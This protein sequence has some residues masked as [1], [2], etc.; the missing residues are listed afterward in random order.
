[1]VS[2]NA[3]W[4]FWSVTL[5]LSTAASADAMLDG[6]GVV[7]VLGLAVLGAVVVRVPFAVAFEG[8]VWVDVVLGVVSVDVLVGAV[9]LGVPV[10]AV[11]LGVLVVVEPVVVV[12]AGLVVVS[13]TNSRVP[14]SAAVLAA[15][16]VVAVP[17]SRLVSWSSAE[18]RLSCAWLTVSWAEDGSSVASSCPWCTCCPTLT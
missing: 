5:A 10:G 11:R 17:S 14:E 1:L 16:A 7:V 4:A 6:D 2:E 9:R 8:A 13:A 18:F 3:V 15:E 12:V